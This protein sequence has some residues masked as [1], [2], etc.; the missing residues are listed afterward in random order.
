[1]NDDE[2]RHPVAFIIIDIGVAIAGLWLMIYLKEHYAH[3]LG[4]W[5]VSFF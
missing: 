5:I 2:N 4:E 1:M 3:D